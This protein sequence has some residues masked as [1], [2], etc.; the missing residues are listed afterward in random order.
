M[1]PNDRDHAQ[2]FETLLLP[3]RDAAYNLALW[4]VGNRAD[5][6]DVAQDAI[7]R[8]WRGIDS[9]RGA[10]VRP[11]LLRIVRNTAYT[12]L[13]RRRRHANVV[14]I[15]DG[16]RFR[17]ARGKTFEPVD[18]TP[19][20]DVGLIGAEHRAELSRALLEL[21]AALRET[22]VLREMEELSYREIAEIMETPVGT[23]MSRLSRARE[24]LRRVLE[25]RQKDA[26]R[27][28]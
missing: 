12:H 16:G 5:A 18:E 11:W 8:A 6:E 27:A 26:N 28:L 15:E 10:V 3:H 22:L 19:G 24:Q 25:A 17:D 14:P 7:V 23:V 20:A 21:P 13:E 1:D 9:L 4:L 2:A